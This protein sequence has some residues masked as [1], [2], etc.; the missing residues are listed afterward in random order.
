MSIP[1]LFFF[2]CLS[3]PNPYGSLPMADIVD[4]LLK[5]Y[6]QHKINFNGLSCDTCTDLRMEMLIRH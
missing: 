5:I 1:I 4:S 2:Y 3:S 6:V